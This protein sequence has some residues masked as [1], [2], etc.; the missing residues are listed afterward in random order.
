[1]LKK[2]VFKFCCKSADLSPRGPAVS[3]SDLKLQREL[4]RQQQEFLQRQQE[5]LQ[6]SQSQQAQA[7]KQQERLCDQIKHLGNMLCYFHFPGL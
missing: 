4:V 5:Q 6:Q 2:N 3:E 7:L 1:M